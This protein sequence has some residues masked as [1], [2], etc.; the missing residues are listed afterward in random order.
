MKR[1]APNT[2]EYLKKKG[3]NGFFI[4]VFIALSMAGIIVLL[5]KL[6]GI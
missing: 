3:V 4:E 6:M 2:Y 5:S 1:F